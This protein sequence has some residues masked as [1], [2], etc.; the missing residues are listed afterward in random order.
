MYANPLKSKLANGEP[1]TGCIIQG[2]LPALA[3][4]CG[5]TGFDFAWI[6]AEHG[7]LSERDCEEL[8]RAAENRRIV[9]LVR[10]PAAM[11]HIILRY[12]DV[13]AMGVIVPGVTGPED[14]AAAVRAVKYYPRGDRGLTTARAADFGL[15]KPLTEYVTE[16][17]AETMV[18]AI[19]ETPAAIDRLEEIFAVDG[20]DAAIF[21]GTDLSLAMGLPGQ[22][23]HPRVQEAFER[24]IEAGRRSGK[25]VGTV[26]RPGESAPEL[27]GR[28]LT[29][30]IAN[31]YSLF[32]AG[33]KNFVAA[34][35]A[36][37]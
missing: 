8:A 3:E 17:N 2:A 16:A 6:D 13:G 29:I 4:I 9:P 33:A 11:P 12:M 36:K 30:L 14:V 15:V 37:Q 27:I 32:A 24:F 21:G 20:L 25:P 7:P 26:L 22:W 28:G 35:K 34:V 1:V 5:L 10:V 19:I 31:A 18:I 23:L